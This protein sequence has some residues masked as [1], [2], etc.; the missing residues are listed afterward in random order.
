MLNVA[1]RLSGA[2][3]AFLLTIM[4]ARTMEPSGFAQVSVMLAWLAV[5]TALGGLSMPLV[6]VRF[7]GDYVAQGRPDLAR[8]VLVFSA[9]C[10]LATATIVGAGVWAA[11]HIGWLSLSPAATEL[12]KL[13]VLLLL[14]NVMLTLVSG[15]LQALNHPVLAETLGSVLR[16]LLMLAGLACL[17]PSPP[18]ALLT[19]QTVMALY[20]A[21]SLLLLV[22]AGVLVWRLQRRH[23]KGASAAAYVPAQWLHVALGLFAVL[24]TVSISERIDLLMLG[25]LAPD[26]EIAVYA[27]AQRFGQTLLLATTAVSAVLAPQFAACLPSLREGRQ[28]QAQA[29]V[30]STA[31]LT[32]WTCAAAWLAFAATGPWLLMLY[33]KS[34]SGAYLPLMILVTGQLAACLFGPAILISTLSGNVRYTLLVLGTGMLLNAGLNWITVPHM[35][36]LGAA[37]ATA[38]GTLA[39]SMLAWLFMRRQLGIET[40]VFAP[41]VVLAS[42]AIP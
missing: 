9:F 33:G 23:F 25:W 16:S 3:L 37:T 36:A 20:L 2:A 19:P 21:V 4:L 22:V 32:L 15:I 13:G 11:L 8:G 24:V 34:Y 39:S 27:A 28:A 10:A 26:S 6:V 5:A 12:A 30:R 40:S 38:V 14:P 42:Q 1:A 31:R 29:L 41:A 7:V 35:G 17:W 18:I